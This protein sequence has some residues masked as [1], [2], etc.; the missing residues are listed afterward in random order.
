MNLFLQTL[1]AHERT[2]SRVRARVL[3]VNVGKKCNQICAHCHVNAGPARREEMSGES[4]D[5]ILS[6]LARHD[7]PTLDVTGGAPEMN[8]HFKRLVEGGKRLGR[9]VMDRCNLTIC[10]EPGHEELPE[11][12]AR[13]GVEIVASLPCYGPENVDLQRGQGTFE[14]SI[15]VLR[16]LNALG[17]GR[18]N[19]E[20]ALHLVYNPLGATLPPGQAALEAAYK[21]RLHQD[22]GIRFNRL[23]ALANLPIARFASQLR[24]EGK[25]DEYHDL[26]RLNFNAGTLDGLMCR[27]TINVDWRGRVYD[28]DFNQMLNLRRQEAPSVW[29]LEP[30]DLEGQ[31]I[32]TG[33]HC[34]GCTAGAG[35]SCGGALAA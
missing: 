8:P 17:Y 6:W 12:L 5:K 3:Q 24:R 31:Q 2:L 21:E 13:H 19:G 28:C 32:H 25:L 11:F 26:L 22:F 29:D 7:I 18:E 10:E 33:A 35:S 16:R 20:L 23:F 34:F 15:R 27:D 14:K 4:V 9:H 30:R 1:G